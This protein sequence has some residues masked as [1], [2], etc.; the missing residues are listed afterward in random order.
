M[1]I[2]NQTVISIGGGAAYQLERRYAG[3]LGPD[4]KARWSGNN[5]KRFR[6]AATKLIDD[7]LLNE[8][9][10]PE[11]VQNVARDLRELVTDEDLFGDALQVLSRTLGYLN[12]PE[13]IQYINEAGLVKNLNFKLVLHRVEIPLTY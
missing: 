5:R 9:V 11:Y 10:A 8:F 12:W 1:S 7:A 3:L 2:R 13:F 4:Y 6:M